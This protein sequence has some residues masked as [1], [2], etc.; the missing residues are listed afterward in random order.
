MYGHAICNIMKKD[1]QGENIVR[2]SSILTRKTCTEN[3][4]DAKVPG[5]GRQ[6]RSLLY[7]KVEA[8]DRPAGVR[9]SSPLSFFPKLDPSDTH[10]THRR[11]DHRLYL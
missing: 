1:H 3:Y 11:E 5:G 4:G 6:T 8:A 10:R 2:K 9:V 7:I